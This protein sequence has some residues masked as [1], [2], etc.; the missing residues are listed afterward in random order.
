METKKDWEWLA[1][2]SEKIISLLVKENCT[3][4]EAFKV[5]DCV[6]KHLSTEN[7]VTPVQAESKSTA[8]DNR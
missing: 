6:E 2:T 5:L 3:V 7:F 4:G 1:D 8:S